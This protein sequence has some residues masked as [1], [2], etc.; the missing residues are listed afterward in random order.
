MPSGPNG[1]NFIDRGPH[2]MEHPGSI[3][4]K[5]AWNNFLS[6][7]AISYVAP[8]QAT[9]QHTGHQHDA[10]CVHECYWNTELLDKWKDCYRVD[11]D[12]ACEKKGVS[13]INY[14][15]L[16][17]LASHASKILI[18]KLSLKHTAN[19]NVGDTINHNDN[20]IKIGL[21]IPE[22]PF[23]PL[24]VLV[25]HALNVAVGDGFFR[26]VDPLTS[27]RCSEKNTRCSAVVLIPMETEEAPER[28]RHILADADPN[29]ILVA[30]GRDTENL[31]EILG[32]NP[33]PSIQLMDYSLI[34][35]EALSLI[36]NQSESGDM[37][38]NRLYPSGIRDVSIDSLR[39]P[40]GIPGYCWDVAR[41]VAWGSQRLCDI[42][43]D[44]N[45]E[46]NFSAS[47]KEM[48]DARHIMSHVV[49][50]SG[51][52]GK[53]KGCVSSLQ[54][55]QHYIRAKNQAH[56]I[57]SKSTVLLASA[58]TFDPC[59]SDVL[60]TFVANATLAVAPRD[61]LYGHDDDIGHGS[62][63]CGDNKIRFRGLTRLLRQLEVTHVLCTPTLWAAVEGDP[64]QNVPSLEVVALGGEPIPKAMR[65]RWARC[66]NLSSSDALECWD[67][68]YPRLF[69]TYGVTEA[70]VYQTCGEVVQ[71]NGT[72]M[73]IG[74]TQGQSVGQPLLGSKVQICRPLSHD[75][76][77]TS[78]VPEALQSAK[79]DTDPVIGEVVLS[80]AQVDSLSSYLNLPELTKSVFI[81]R[82]SA[83]NSTQED[84]F[85]YR[86]GDLG[87]VNTITNNLHILGRI[88]GDGMIKL[89]GVRIELAEIESALIDD[90]VNETKAGG[91][92]IDCMATTTA[93]SPS[94]DTESS[95]SM[96]KQLIAYCIVSP[97][98]LSELR[99]VPEQLKTGLII[100]PGPLLTALRARCD[101][102]VRKGCTPSFFVLID[103]LPLS[104]T[105]K[106][107][108]S[109]LPSLENCQ[110]MGC[111]DGDGETLWR[112]GT[113]GP[114]VADKV[115]E[116]LNLQPC[117]RAL[118]TRGSNFFALGGD[119]LAATRVTRG[120]YA[121]HH[122][123]LN[124]RNI[125]GETGT[126]D[127][128][129]AAKYLLQSPTLGDYVKF[130]HTHSAFEK[131]RSQRDVNTEN[132]EE[133]P[134][135]TSPTDSVEYHKNVLYDG[136][137]EAISLGLTCVAISLLDLGVDPNISSM[138][139]K[140]RL[141]KV[142]DRN[143]QRALFHAN[144]LH[145]AC[146]RGEPLLVKR[147]LAAGCRSNIPDAQGYFPI[148][149]AC[150]RIEDHSTVPKD[151]D[152]TITSNQD[153]INRLEVV[154]MLLEKTPI[155]IK[156]ANKQTI[157]HSA[158][159]SGH[160]RLLRYIM[161]E[162]RIA[163]ETVGI[164]FKSHNN[165][166]DKIF[167]W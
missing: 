112:F 42:T 65:A 84:E 105:G 102:K 143:Q 4:Q 60:A 35:R 63:R 124:S 91:L 76:P 129:F 86:T 87:Y 157:L 67:R 122:G 57:S 64:P 85:F 153:D 59:F 134:P 44:N 49:Y 116:C 74:S 142:K 130:L 62:E 7:P 152:Y 108:R 88:K 167:D 45:G 111:N 23:L 120:L 146:V 69:A 70:C 47:I 25:V 158:A 32:S 46:Y 58:I 54:S 101:R 140:L 71:V 39:Y 28:L 27:V 97:L 20:S 141:G 160:C 61:R 33:S 8:R 17:L 103:R 139:G 106:R 133:H 113:A 13:S 92:V 93:A 68:E 5:E 3:S 109:R 148:H 31:I 9:A 36:E 104:P 19:G 38:L 137:I 131:H 22:G 96:H 132:F 1:V 77:N 29:V 2:K 115:C 166:P 163:S 125:G 126:L 95:D 6:F 10:P 150:S 43:G 83:P 117:Q 48:N 121:L 155:S 114:I 147:L 123:V 118:V 21:A 30:P 100:P 56:D 18:Q 90:D 53:P 145:L 99:I 41:L 26:V 154:K 110:L 14:G 94:G 164:K 81:H 12:A 79:G 98:C 162:W 72:N 151:Q 37:I 128:P 66:Q 51:T 149:L 135:E 144:P 161:R 89:N 138:G 16:L 156:D 55:L 119:S 50:T 40:H 159:R 52:T 15:S 34:V 80:G 82:N 11:G 127:G 73:Q 24:F 78:F 136:L 107:D 75:S 165:A